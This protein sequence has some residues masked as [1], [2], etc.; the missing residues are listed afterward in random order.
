MLLNQRAVSIVE[1]LVELFFLFFA[2]H[3]LAKK[4]GDQYSQSGPNKLHV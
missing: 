2:A 4:I 1:V 3:K